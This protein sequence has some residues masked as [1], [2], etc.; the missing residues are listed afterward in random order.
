[1][2][3]AILPTLLLGALATSASAQCAASDPAH[4]APTVLESYHRAKSLIDAAVEAHGGLEALRAATHVRVVM[5]GHDYHRTQGRRIAAPYD[6][7]LRRNDVM[8]D[9]G[10]RQLVSEQTRGYPGGFF[11]TTRYVSDGDRFYSVAPRNRNY[12]E[13]QGWDPAERQFGNLFAVPTWYLLAALESPARGARRYLGRMRLGNDG[14][15]VEAVHFTIPNGGNIIIGLNPATH[16]L[17]ATLSVGTDVF[18]GDTEVYTEFLEW[19]NLGGVLLPTYA[20]AMRAGEPTSRLRYVSATPGYV[21]PD[22]LLSPPPG[23]T[24]APAAPVREPV[25]ELASGVWMVGTGSRSLA[26]AFGDHLVVVDAPSSGSADVIARAAA[27]APGKPIRYVV[28]TH[29][30]DDHFFG[31]RYHAQAGSRIVTT[32]GN[33]EYLRR[34][35]AAPMSTVMLAANQ[36][37]PIERY[38]VET[39]DGDQRVFSDGTRRLE[40]HRIRSP[41]AEEMLIAWLPA[42]GILYHADLIEAPQGVALRGANAETTLH[43]ADVIRQK[44]WNVRVFAGAHGTLESPAVFDELVRL[45]IIPPAP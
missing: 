35:M 34:M 1:M 28:P 15:V 19:R 32:P 33:L 39:I 4:R 24:I 17:R 9:I 36:T 29:H 42:E 14:A 31:V 5:E 3:K 45:P 21:I 16:R 18:T 20:V 7:T 43:L 40:I 41:H 6:S 27:F 22:S 11:Y 37:P 13:H 38:E 12:S 8:I 23:Y 44:G 10:R 26:V 25:E 2:K 30:H